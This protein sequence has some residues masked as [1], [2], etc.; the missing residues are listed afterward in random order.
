MSG[1]IRVVGMLGCLA[2]AIGASP[3]LAAEATVPSEQDIFKG[4]RPAPK[5]LGAHQ[6]APVFGT[7][8]GATENAN[9]HNATLPSDGSPSSPGKPK[10]PASGAATSHVQ[11][12]PEPRPAFTFNTIQ[13][14]FGSAEIT[15]ESSETLRNLGNALNHGL[16]DQK[17]FVIEGH[18]D[19]TGTRAYN[20]ELSKRRADA[21]KDYLVNQMGVSADRL[22]SFGKGFSEPADPKHPYA[23]ENRRVRVVNPGS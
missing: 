7:V 22:Q 17:A 18:T 2:F 21:V 13:F 5:G 16:A 10:R 12:S 4:L 23:A 1:R 6:G 3:L 11:A 19:R 9:V 8:P 15:P 20:D 14:T